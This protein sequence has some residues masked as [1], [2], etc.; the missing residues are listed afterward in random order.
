MFVKLSLRE[1][2]NKMLFQLGCGLDVLLA[3]VI[4]YNGIFLDSL[5]E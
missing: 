1:I 3:N 4:F 2:D 5:D